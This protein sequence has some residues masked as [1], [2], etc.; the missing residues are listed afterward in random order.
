MW[1]VALT[2]FSLFW[3]GFQLI[4]LEA[5]SPI[6]WLFLIGDLALG[7]LLFIA[8]WYQDIMKEDKKYEEK[9]EV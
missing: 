9:E 1:R 4:F 2:I 3:V 8:S 7:L 5:D 6:T